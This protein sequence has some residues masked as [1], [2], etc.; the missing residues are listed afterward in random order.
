MNKFRDFPKAEIRKNNYFT[1]WS[2]VAISVILIGVTTAITEK[3]QYKDS[4]PITGTLA[5]LIGLFFIFYGAYFLF[6]LI[7]IAEKIEKSHENYHD[8][9]NF[10]DTI[11][12]YD[13]EFSVINTYVVIGKSTHPAYY[14]FLKIKLKKNLLANI[15]IKQRDRFEYLCWKAGFTRFLDTLTGNYYFDSRYKVTCFNKERF[16]S[17]FTNE[18]LKL[19]ELFDRDYPPIRA[20]NGIL[21]IEDDCVKYKEGPYNGEHKIF[22]PHR[23]IIEDLFTELIQIISA[24]EKNIPMV[25][26]EENEKN[27]IITIRENETKQQERVNRIFN[28]FLNSY[29][30]VLYTF[31]TIYF[32]ISIIDKIFH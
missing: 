32:V 19:L 13:V 18:I 12:G 25:P 11:Y 24:I 8:L 20:K 4:S 7:F 6:H 1:L 2:L 10:E 26:D 17:I 27:L 22:D 31:L 30:Y 14:Y 5:V 16:Q 9:E 23:G 15:H 3:F 28:N 29:S 21:E